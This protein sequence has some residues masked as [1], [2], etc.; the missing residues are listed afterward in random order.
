MVTRRWHI[1]VAG[2][3]GAAA[4][5]F[6]GLLLIGLTLYLPD[7]SPGGLH[8]NYLGLLLFPAV[9]IGFLLG[10]GLAALTMRRPNHSE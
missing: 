7:L 5:F 2:G 8:H 1:A 10:A 4:V 3:I 9:G 6:L